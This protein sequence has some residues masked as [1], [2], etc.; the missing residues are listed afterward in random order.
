MQK[1][2]IKIR[3][4]ALAPGDTSIF[5]NH[6]KSLWKEQK[7]SGSEIN[8]GTKELGRI[9][10]G[11]TVLKVDPNTGLNIIEHSKRPA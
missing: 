3:D 1:N 5:V 9:C 11:S 7:L 6:P 8:A 2:L 10:R 4:E